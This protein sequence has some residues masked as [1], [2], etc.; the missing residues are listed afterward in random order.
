MSKIK[1]GIVGYGNLGKG[2]IEAI[3]QTQDMELVAVFTR[4]DPQHLHLDDQNVKVAHI[5]EASDYKNDIDV[6]LLCGGSATDL[7]EQ[8][9]YFASMF[10]TVDSFDTHAKIPEFYKSVNEVATKN[11]TTA[12]ISVG[13]D[14]GLFSINRVMA[15]AI[16]PNGENYTF[17]GKGL[18]QGHSDAVRRVT[19]VKN[20][21]QYTI[22]SEDAIENVRSGENPE[23]S[24]AEKHNRVCYVVAE[25][26]ADQAAIEHEIKTMP[27]YFAEYNTEVNFISEE[28]LKRDHSKAPHGGFVI[29][30]GNTGAGHKQIYEFSLKLDSNPEFTSSVLVAYARAA[31]RLNNEKQFGAKT[32]YDVAPGYISPRSP[33]ELRRDYL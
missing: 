3:K 24:T 6:M 25:E 26:G 20:G 1:L 31:Y 12:I 29:R 28:E 7:P 17:W 22:P 21:V 2:A 23:L 14:P 10:N 33:E 5:S 9:P 16:I 30:G 13:W 18:S 8:T 4:R 15:D 32:V 11:N 19:G 27:N